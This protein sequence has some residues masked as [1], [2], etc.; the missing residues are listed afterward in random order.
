MRA[1][2]VGAT[3]SRERR[4]E[5]TEGDLKRAR[6]RTGR[7][8][9][10]IRGPVSAP[11]LCA[12]GDPGREQA[13]AYPPHGWGREGADGGALYY[14]HPLRKNFRKFTVPII[15]YHNRWGLFFYPHPILQRGGGGSENQKTLPPPS[16]SIENQRLNLFG[17]GRWG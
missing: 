6:E 8:E 16:Y 9:R 17:W 10:T 2:A 15:H 13:R 1:K 5:R 7:A 11:A 14:I 3:R 12:G 4:A